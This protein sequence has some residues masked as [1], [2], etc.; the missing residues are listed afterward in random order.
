MRPLNK[1][2]SIK[3]FVPLIVAVGLIV[4]VAI[5]K[6]SYITGLLGAIVGFYFSRAI[7]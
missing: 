7:K 6:D 1:I 5:G 2:I 4:L 3:D